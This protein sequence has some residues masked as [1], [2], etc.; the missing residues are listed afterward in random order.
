MHSETENNYLLDGLKTLNVFT[1]NGAQYSD[2]FTQQL[3]DYIQ[4]WITNC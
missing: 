4:Q 1:L 2:K 3:D